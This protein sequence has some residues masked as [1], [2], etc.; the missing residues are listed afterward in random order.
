MFIPFSKKYIKK[1]WE[2]SNARIHGSTKKVELEKNYLKYAR[3]IESLIYN[4]KKI[5]EILDVG[6][7]DGELSAKLSLIFKDSNIDGL[8]QSETLLKK[9]KDKKIGNAYLQSCTD[10]WTNINKKYDLII[11][12]GVI[13]YLNYG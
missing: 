6:C 5:K 10:K 8:E 11:L 2:K 7:A 9:Y 4:K 3:K 13:Q 1:Y 12:N